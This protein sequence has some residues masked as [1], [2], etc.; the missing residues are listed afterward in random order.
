MSDDQ[1]RGFW[2]RLEGAWQR[3]E[4]DKLLYQTI[5]GWSGASSVTVLLTDPDAATEPLS[6]LARRFAGDALSYR[7]AT[8]SLEAQVRLKGC[9]RHDDTACHR[10]LV[11]HEDRKTDNVLR[12]CSAVVDVEFDL[13]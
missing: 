12:D 11:R 13:R 10:Y 3:L 8:L 4:I 1:Q 9:E 6:L 2:L 5:P 7:T